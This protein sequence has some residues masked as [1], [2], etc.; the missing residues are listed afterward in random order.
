MIKCDGCGREAP[1]VTCQGDV[2]NDCVKLADLSYRD[3]ISPGAAMI[4][5][6]AQETVFDD[7]D[8]DDEDEFEL[9]DDEDEEED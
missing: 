6:Q 4:M 5:T 1:E 7:G 8:D 2:C 3:A 9:E